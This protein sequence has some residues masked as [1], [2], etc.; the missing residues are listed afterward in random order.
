VQMSIFVVRAFLRLREWVVGQAD[1][2]SRL[3]EL[4][5]VAKHVVH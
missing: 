3:A 5:V 4:D 1:L 2:A